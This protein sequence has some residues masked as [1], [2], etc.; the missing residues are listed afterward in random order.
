MSDNKENEQIIQTLTAHQA[1]SANYLNWLTAGILIIAVATLFISITTYSYTFRPQTDPHNTNYE[2][3]AN[4]G[5]VDAQIILADYSLTIGDFEKSL[6][7]YMVSLSSEGNH[8]AKA[9]NNMGF[10]LATN[11]RLSRYNQEYYL[12]ILEYFQKAARLGSHEALRNEYVLLQTYM[13]IVFM[14]K[15]HLYEMM[16]VEDKLKELELFDHN[17]EILSGGWEYIETTDDISEYKKEMESTGTEYM[18]YLSSVAWKK[19]EDMTINTVTKY[20]VYKR[21]GKKARS[22]EA[23]V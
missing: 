16:I 4:A 6:Y 17:L 20:D 10:I 7:W 23:H 9:F 13:G 15:D 19:D 8:H 14:P 22:E 18:F 3:R 21:T 5:D 2:A 1:R 11:P 12:Q